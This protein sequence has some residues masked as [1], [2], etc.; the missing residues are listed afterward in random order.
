MNASELRKLSTDDL[1]KEHI[2]LLREHFNLRVKKAS[3]QMTQTHNL[4][5]IKRN[6]ARVLTILRE[7]I[8][9]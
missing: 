5:L 1:K 6:I 2:D 3:G 9:K 4:R 8:G 7:K